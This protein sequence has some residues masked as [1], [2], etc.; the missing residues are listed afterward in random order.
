[1]D[2]IYV[3]DLALRCVIGVFP[4][5][6]NIKQDVL[7]NLMLETNMLT[8]SVTDD[9]N[10]TVDYKGLKKRIVEVVEASDCQLIERLAELVAEVCLA[11]AH[12]HAVTVTLDKPGALRYARS[13]AVEIYRT[14]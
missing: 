11:T 9:L 3:R 4:E 13:V 1:M 8:S 2:K 10:D 12:V 7:I 5:E 14:R 6:R